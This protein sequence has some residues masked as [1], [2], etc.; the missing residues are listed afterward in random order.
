M[1]HVGVV[2]GIL[3][4]ARPRQAV[5]RGGARKRESGRLAARQPDRHRIGKLAG[6]QRLKRRLRRGRGARAGRPAAAE[7]PSRAGRP[8]ARRFSDMRAAIAAGNARADRRAA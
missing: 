2:A 7:R 5:A 4:D 8:P 3:D 6:E 1:R